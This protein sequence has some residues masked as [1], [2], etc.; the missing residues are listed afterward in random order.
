MSKIETIK[1]VEEIKVIDLQVLEVLEDSVIVSIDGWRIRAYTK[2]LSKLEKENLAVG[3]IIE[4]RYT[5]DIE[6]IHSV[7]LLPL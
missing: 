3:R 6:D 4:V 5:G 1:E 2:N 7:Q